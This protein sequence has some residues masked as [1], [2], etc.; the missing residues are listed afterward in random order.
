MLGAI[1]ATVTRSLFGDGGA[2]LAAEIP[3][4]A[5]MIVATYIGESSADEELA[6][7]SAA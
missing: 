6:A 3:E 1:E 4:L 2:S 5:H 7:L